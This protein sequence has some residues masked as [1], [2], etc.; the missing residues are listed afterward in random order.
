MTLQLFLKNLS[1]C[2]VFISINFQTGFTSEIRYT[3]LDSILT[4]YDAY[5]EDFIKERE[6][7]GVAIA[8]VINNRVEYIKGFGVKKIGEKDSISIHSVFRIASVSKG[9]ASILSGLLVKNGIFNWDDKVIKHLP[10]FSLKDSS[11]TKKLTIR[12]I[13]SH[14][15]GLIPHAY[16]NLI[17]ANLPFKTII[18]NLKEV[19]V[20]GTVGEHY[21]YQNTVY[22]LISEIIKSAT[23]KKYIELLKRSLIKPLG[24]NDVSFSKT[25]LLET[26]DR[27]YPHIRKNGQWIPTEVRETYYNV[28][29]AAGINA[30]IYDMA[31]WL[32]GLMGGAP[33]VISTDII[34]E[35]CKPIIITPQEKYRFD[36]NNR[37]RYAAYGMGWRIFDYAG[38]TMIFH[39]GGL[40]GY[41]SQLAFLPRYKIGIVTLQN[42]RFRNNFIYKFIDMYFNIEQEQILEQVK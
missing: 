9:F 29:P 14:T 13:L 7:P 4:A 21:G 16:D 24:M 3:K 37:L 23:N 35:V 30:S 34:K 6:A 39:S 20:I 2:I 22:S 8:I 17:E 1:I 42:A 19:A 32:R 26:K 5:V 38:Y 18:Q 12:H 28:P 27:T 25:G 15:S 10:D 31:Y 40:Q 11:T 36:W 33:D 41:L